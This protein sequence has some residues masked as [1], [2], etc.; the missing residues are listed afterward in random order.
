M[1][2]NNIIIDYTNYAIQVRP[3]RKGGIG[4]RRNYGRNFR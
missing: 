1:V 3:Y 4:K 2:D